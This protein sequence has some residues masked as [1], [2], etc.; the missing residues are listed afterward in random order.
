MEEPG[1]EYGADREEAGDVIVPHRLELAMPPSEQAAFH[2]ALRKDYGQIEAL[3]SQVTN[4]DLHTA[5][6]RDSKKEE[7]TGKVIAREKI[8]AR[9]A[10]TG[11]PASN[12][13]VAEGVA[14]TEP[15]LDKKVSSAVLRSPSV[16]RV[17]GPVLPGEGEA[18]GE[19]GSA[20]EEGGNDG[21]DG[22]GAESPN[23]PT[24]RELFNQPRAPKENPFSPRVMH[25][26]KAQDPTSQASAQARRLLR[27]AILHQGRVSVAP[28]RAS[29][30]MHI[31]LK[32]PKF[33]AHAH[34]HTMHIQ[35]PSRLRAL[36]GSALGP[37]PPPVATAAAC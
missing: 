33:C 11:S 23:K 20:G 2:E 9:I 28:P 37:N 34:A 17:R 6:C 3:L 30:P 15:P 12:L 10:G 29:T 16:P 5:E 26:R 19:G 14:L 27:E 1:G 35:A 8:L 21:G 4:V 24:M 18:N 31:L 13:I 22:A 32:G 36:S 7:G 25:R